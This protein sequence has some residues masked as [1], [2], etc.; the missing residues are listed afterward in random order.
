MNNSAE[1]GETIPLL[2]EGFQLLFPAVVESGKASCDRSVIINSVTNALAKLDEVNS[3]IP[4]VQFIIGQ[5]KHN[6]EDVL[7][8]ADRTESLYWDTTAKV[9]QTT[10]DL[11]VKTR[12][13][14]VHS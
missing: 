5:C 2:Y 10:Y 13:A 3:D 8:N 1:F 4:E 12:N 14:L 9:L 7:S 11:I 6:L